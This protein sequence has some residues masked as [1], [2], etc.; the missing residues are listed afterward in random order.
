MICPLSRSEGNT[1]GVS[2]KETCEW[3]DKDAKQCNEKTKADAL[4]NIYEV[5]R[6]C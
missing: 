5:K 3:W 2:C 1:A 4:V 6:E